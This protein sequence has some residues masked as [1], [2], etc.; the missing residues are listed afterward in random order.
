MKRK[1][2]KNSNNKKTAWMR[3][4]EKTFPVNSSSLSLPSSTSSSST[5]ST[6]PLNYLL[7]FYL[8]FFSLF[9]FCCMCVW[10][11]LM[12]RIQKVFFHAV[13]VSSVYFCR[14]VA[15]VRLVLNAFHCTI[16]NIRSLFLAISA[17]F[18]ASAPLRRQS[19]FRCCVWSKSTAVVRAK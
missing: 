12:E 3:E 2:E 18:F 4:R 16:R 7:L 1:K 10:T 15:L 14:L 6:Q 17:H 8:F 9:S 13:F 11:F 19:F 5:S